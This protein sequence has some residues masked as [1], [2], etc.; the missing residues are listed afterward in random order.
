MGAL[1]VRVVAISMGSGADVSG[2]N[3]LSGL[4]ESEF[5]ALE[6]L[7]HINSFSATKVNVGPF[8]FNSNEHNTTFDK[9]VERARLSSKH[10][11]KATGGRRG[12]NFDHTVKTKLEA[13]D[14]E[15]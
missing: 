13:V 10:G 2:A 7:K 14:R 12:M 9:P 6:T 1:F 8:D 3:R 15:H 5:A 11:A 4:D